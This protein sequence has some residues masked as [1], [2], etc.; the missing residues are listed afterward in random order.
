MSL[1]AAQRDAILAEVK[2][3]APNQWAEWEL[4]DSRLYDRKDKIDINL[5]VSNETARGL[6]NWN[7]VEMVFTGEDEPRVVTVPSQDYEMT[8][9]VEVTSDQGTA[10]AG[11]S[12]ETA[13]AIRMG[14]CN[15]LTMQTLNA[16]NVAV[17]QIG[18][19]RFTEKVLDN[20]VFSVV[21]FDL[22]LNTVYISVPDIAQE[23]GAIETITQTAA[24]ELAPPFH[25]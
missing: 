13:A 24:G 14:F 4:T 6:P 19:T 20:Y 25:S 10:S 1:T 5:R 23:V 21:S 11:D 3:Y 2:R 7:Q 18:P 17:S 22:E 9:T 16:A 15:E 12:Q 8:L